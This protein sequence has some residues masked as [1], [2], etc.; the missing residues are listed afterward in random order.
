M[1]RF[2]TSG[3]FDLDVEEIYDEL[4]SYE[5]NELIDILVE[6]GYVIKT[7]SNSKSPDAQ[8]TSEW[9]FTNMIGKIINNRLRLNQEE[10]ELLQKISDRF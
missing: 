7:K 4:S 8:N 1:A 5:I 2:Y 3:D 6:E 10:E 9:L